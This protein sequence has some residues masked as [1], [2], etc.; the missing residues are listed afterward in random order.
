MTDSAAQDVILVD[1]QVA[2]IAS[3]LAALRR[4]GATPRLSQDPH[5][6]AQADHVVLPGV[7]AFGPGMQ[8]LH[9]LGLTQVLGERIRQGQHTLCVCLGLQL[10]THTSQEAPG[11][12]GLGVLDAHVVRFES[13]DVLVPQL[14]WNKVSP[15]DG[16][17]MLQE[18][19]AYFANSYHLDR[20][21]EGWRGATSTHGE[22]FVAAVERGGVLACQFH[23]ELSG[24]WGL[25]LMRRWLTFDGAR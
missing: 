14:G 6:I 21:P 23:P 22:V 25:E 15:E 11:V 7:G 3:M 8:R 24:V 5:E 12:A 1:T 17:A 2:N 10:L 20:I 4:L 18:G 19:Y 16:C 13:P 9:E